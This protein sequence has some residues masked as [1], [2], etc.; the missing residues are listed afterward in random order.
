MKEFSY[1]YDFG[2]SWLHRIEILGTE[3][4]AEDNAKPRCLA[5][6]RAGPLEDVGGSEG[7]LEI[8]K[9]LAA[10]SHPDHKNAMRRI[11]GTNFHPDYFNIDET[12]KEL[13]RYRWRAP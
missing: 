3:P 10:S 8:L 6:E 7:Y 11:E 1:E 12:N 2:D 4:L 9:A 5:G 13:N